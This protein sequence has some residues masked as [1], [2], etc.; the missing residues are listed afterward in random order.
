[1]ALASGTI[2]Y[3]MAIVDREDLVAF[4]SVNPLN[5]QR[6]DPTDVTTAEMTPF[7]SI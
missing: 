2:Q 5:P 7:F 6:L 4:T 1:M 3:L